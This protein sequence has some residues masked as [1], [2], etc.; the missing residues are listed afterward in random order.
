MYSQLYFI[1]IS[2][3]LGAMLNS[4]VHVLMYSYY[5][6]SAIGPSLQPYLWWKKYLT[7]IQLVSIFISILYRDLKKLSGLLQAYLVYKTLDS[8]HKK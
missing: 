4:M 6:L 8:A 2:A 1:L 3:F 7:M 5:G